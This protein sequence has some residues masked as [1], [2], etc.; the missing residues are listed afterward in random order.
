MNSLTSLS[1]QKLCELLPQECIETLVNQEIEP[2]TVYVVGKRIF[3]TREQAEI[4]RSLQIYADHSVL[5]VVLDWKVSDTL[6]AYMKTQKLYPKSKLICH[7]K[8]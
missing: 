6:Y 5:R 7:R 1:A 2:R 4:I 8:T 3:K